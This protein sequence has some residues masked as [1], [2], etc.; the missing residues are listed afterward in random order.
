VQIAEGNSSF[1]VIRT[2]IS[3]LG[4]VLLHFDH[5]QS[6]RELAKSCQLSPEQIYDSMFES[7]LVRDYELGRIS[8]AEFARQSMQRLNVNLE[9]DLIREIWSDI[10]YPVTGMEELIISLKE[11]YRMVL[12]SNTNEWHFEH[13][14]KKFPVVRLFEHF[15]LSYRLGCQKPDREIF[16]KALAMAN[17]RPEETLYVDDIPAYVE[18]ARRLGMKAVCFK[19][20][21][22]L[23]DEM[24]S[25]GMACP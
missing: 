18:S 25:A 21:D 20:R 11:S 3:D 2:I 12:L 23:T 1:D 16:E 7:H 6:C 24:K 4:N 15:A 13:C 17:A 19:D 14:H 8:S 22:Q 9:L 5:M 10:F